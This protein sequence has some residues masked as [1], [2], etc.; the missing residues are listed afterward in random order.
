[1]GVGVGEVMLCISGLGRHGV[2]KDT[3]RT[4]TN[5]MLSTMATSALEDGVC[6][7]QEIA[8]HSRVG[9]PHG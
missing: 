4:P 5:T 3:V 6:A 2:D 1:M 8:N 9:E 7:G